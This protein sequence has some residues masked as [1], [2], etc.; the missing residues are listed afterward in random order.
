MFVILAGEGASDMGLAIPGE[1]RPGPMAYIVDQLIFKKF[2]FS[3]LES[4]LVYWVSRAE[5]SSIS[6]QQDLRP[7][8]ILPGARRGVGHAG[9]ARHAAALAWYAKSKEAEEGDKSIAVIFRDSDG[10]QSASNDNWDRLVEAIESGF[11]AMSFSRGVAMV[12]KPKQEAWILC[13]KKDDAYMH[14]HLLEQESGND[15]CLNPLKDQ[16]AKICGG[17]PNTEV[18]SEWV[19]TGQVDIERIEMP[20]F[21]RFREAMSLAMQ[22]VAVKNKA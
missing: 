22:N 17:E 19:V 10:T 20:S 9:H 4:G 16:L 6:K 8:M 12:P 15:H 21:S 14:C 13:A 1:A 11:S 3:P 2:E 7:R 18:M 5:L